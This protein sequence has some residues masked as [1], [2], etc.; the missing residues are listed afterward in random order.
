MGMGIYLEDILLFWIEYQI[1]LIECVDFVHFPI[2]EAGGEN[3][4]QKKKYWKHKY[5]WYTLPYVL[6][7]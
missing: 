4:K 5:F 6:N 2:E 3:A 7:K 1:Y